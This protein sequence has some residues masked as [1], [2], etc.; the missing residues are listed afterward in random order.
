MQPNQILGQLQLIQVQIIHSVFFSLEKLIIGQQLLVIMLYLKSH[1]NAE[2]LSVQVKSSGSSPTLQ[3]RT[4]NPSSSTQYITPQ[5]RYDAL[6]QVTVNRDSNLKSSNIK[7]GTSIFGIIGNYTG[8]GYQVK[9]SFLSPSLGSFSTNIPSSIT[10]IQGM[11]FVQLESSSSGR[12][13]ITS[14]CCP[15][16]FTLANYTH[17]LFSLVYLTFDF[18]PYIATTQSIYGCSPAINNGHWY[19][20]MDGYENGGFYGK[21]YLQIYWY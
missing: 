10:T 8:S 5:S 17:F 1:F 16:P 14:F 20:N 12:P 18:S 6:S 15:Q 11:F 4:V 13:C 21:S 9:R 7:S 2:I 3:S 19:F